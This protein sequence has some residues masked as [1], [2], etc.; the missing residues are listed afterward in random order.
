MVRLH[1]ERVLV[2]V[3]AW[4]RLFTVGVVLIAFTTGTAPADAAPRR[5]PD[6]PATIGPSTPGQAL[7]PPGLQPSRKGNR[8]SAGN[9]PG[10][11]TD[12]AVYAYDAAGRLVG[13]TDPK[14]ETAHYRYDAA[15]NRLGIDRYGSGTLSVLSVVPTRARAGTKVT[16]SGT[17]FA[18]VAADN[19]V[20]FAGKD[21]EVVS[22]SA[23]RLVVTVPNDVPAGKVSV[24]AGGTTAES[25]EPFA[26]APDA[27]RITKVEPA[28]GPPGTEVTITGANFFPEA[29]DNVVRFNGV[30]A[31]VLRAAEGALTVLVPGAAQ[32]GRME[33]ET[34]SG[35][36]TSSGDFTVPLSGDEALYDTTARASADDADPTLL[37]VTSS[38]HQ[39]RIL[40]DAD[41]GDS[42]GFG[43]TNSTYQ[44][45][46]GFRLV[47][48]R[49]EEVGL[50]TLS[51]RSASWH[52]ANLQV[53]GTYQF[54]LD[55]RKDNPGSV[56][57]LISKAAGGELKSDGPTV[58][59]QISR[60]GQG[61][62]WSVEGRAGESL[63]IGVEAGG[64][65]G[66]LRGD[67]YRPDGSQGEHLIVPGRGSASLSIPALPQS[68]T[69]VLVL[70]PDN[71]GTPTLRLTA[72]HSADAGRLTS[73]GPPPVLDMSRPGQGG[74]ATFEAKAG[75]S[76][77]LAA[78]GTT[79]N[80]AVDVLQP[81]GRTAGSFTAMKGR[82][83]DWDSPPLLV[84]GI[85]TVR[86]TP[87]NTDTGK[88]TLT[89]SRP[90][91]LG[92]LPA[93]GDPVALKVTRAGQNGV[94]SFGGRDGTAPAL[95]IAGNTFAKSLFVTVLAPSGAKVLNDGLVGAGRPATFSLPKLSESGNYRVVIAP[96]FAAT[97]SLN[98]SVKGATEVRAS[99][100]PAARPMDRAVM[101]PDTW[102]PDPASLDGQD[103]VTRRGSVPKT[104]GTLW[105]EGDRT[106]L[107][108]H[109]LKLNGLPL[110]KVKV[111]VG[112]VSSLTDEHGRFLLSGIDENAT[113]L[114]VDGS[115]A[116]TK[117]REY[118]VFHIRVRPKDRKIVELGFPVWMT[119]LD[120]AHT[121]SFAA[122]A[123][124]DVVLKTP[125]I[126]GLEVRIPK[127]SVVRDGTG[128]PVTR[129][130][131]TPIPIDRAPYPLPTNRVVPV[132]FTVQPGGTY[133]FPKG[134]QIIYPNYTHEPPGTRVEFMDYDPKGKGWYV[135]GHGA[136]S[137]D[138]R[139][140]VPDEKTRV[141]AFHGAMFNIS[142]LIPWDL[143]RIA[144]VGD[145][146]SGDPVDLGTGLL[147]DA[148]TDLAVADPLGSA[149]VNRT[150]WQGDTRSRAF[151]IGR[152]LSYNA[153]LNSK[154]Q[155]K[156][157]D[158]YLPGGQ[159]VHYVRTSSGTGY[160]DAVFEPSG[161]PSGFH[162]TKIYWNNASG[163]DLRF[164]DGSTWVFPQYGA[165]S[166]VRDR[167]GNS[168][169]IERESFN[170][171][172]SQVNRIVTPG[173]RWIELSWDAQ[174]RVREARDNLG[175][176]TGY[177]YDSAG[178]LETVTDPAG[179][180]SRYTYDGSSNRI[181]SATDARGITYMAN[182]YDAGGRVKEQTLTEGAKFS[183]SYTTDGTGKVA[184]TEVERPGGSV[185]K[186]TFDVE[187]FGVSDTVAHGTDLARKTVY[188]RGKNHRI[189]AVVDPFGRRTE[190]HYDAVGHITSTTEMAGTDKAR[191]SGRTD[192]D[193][194]FDQVSRSTDRLGNATSFGYDVQGDL[195]TITDA[196]GRRTAIDYTPQGQVSKV[197][198]AAGAVS[199]YSYS[200]GE[201]VAV[202]DAEGRVS[203]QFKD[204]VGRPTR[205]SDAAG[206][207]ST[208]AYDKLNQTVRTAD[209]LGSSIAF[210]YDDNG[211]L[212]S[213]TDTLGKTATWTY[214]DADRQR[215]ATDALRA[216]ASFAYDLAGRI[217]RATAR[218]GKAATVD[219]D[220]LGRP[221]A[222]AYG[223]DGGGAAESTATYDY[224]E[225]DRLRQITDSASG[226]QSF[227]YDDYDRTKSV[228]GPTGEVTYGY[229]QADRRIQM[230]AAGTGT[231][232]GYDKSGVLTSLKSGS[233]TV[234]FAL[235]AVG[236]EKTATLPG[237]WTRTTDLD[238]S[239]I[240][241]AVSYARSGAVVGDL[242]YSRDERGLQ[243]GLSGKLA[244]VALPAAETGAVFDDANRLTTLG[245][246][247]FAYDKDGRL[248][249]DGLRDYTWNARGQLTGLT[250]NGAT[251]SFG[252]DP[253][254]GRV[255]K[256]VDGKA[257][258]FLTDNG[259]PLAE[260]DGSG[261]PSATVTASGVD[262]FLTRTEGGRTQ[263]YLTDAMGSVVGLAN[264]DGTIAATYAYD[265][266]GQ[267]QSDGSASSNPYTFTGREDDGTGLLY[268]RSR[269]YDPA[270][271]RFISQD[272]I[273]QA[274]GPNLYQYALSSPTT[275]TDPSGNNPMI[276]GCVV[277]GLMDGGI[278]WL[279][280]RLSGRKVSWGQVATS[281]ASG[282]LTG[283]FMDGLGAFMGAR[284]GSKAAQCLK[285]SFTPDTPVLMADGTTKEIADVRV[286][287]RVIA[288]D[289]E[290]GESGARA[291]TALIRG[292]GEKRLVDLTI[293]GPG[294]PDEPKAGHLTATD[295]H[296]FWVP[297]LHRWVPAEKLKPGQWLRTSSGTWVQ[298]AAVSHRAAKSAVNNLTVV[299]LH[300][301]YVLAG[302]SPVLVH[303]CRE[304]FAT[305]YLDRVEGHATVK[306]EMGD[307]VLHTEQIGRPGTYAVPAIRTAP[308]SP[309]TIKVRIP[310]PNAGGALAYQEVKLGKNLGRYD[311][312]T[313]SCV[314]Y[315]AEVLQAGGVTDLPD[316]TSSLEL[317]KYLIRRHNTG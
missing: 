229:D 64:A 120:T 169:R 34:P 56:S 79:V 225:Q 185:R 207:E 146:L 256:Q 15:G 236:R 234:S 172:K 140:V 151:G 58:T 278:D 204:A 91:D 9:G 238:G 179:R 132:F 129:L 311:L 274:G 19:R 197:T 309:T 135:Y 1:G 267:V 180:T 61:G 163:W 228:L 6:L 37:T 98:L 255:S 122:P 18:S 117:D 288:T 224:D 74:V 141:W 211:N 86:V 134:A 167:H 301:Y 59:T 108:G 250:R 31:R 150:Y 73:D 245:G 188:E 54:V 78:T 62:R 156:E 304:G 300:T 168:V 107:T 230:T 13:V 231:A 244:K 235:D 11:T 251:S 289:P 243:A 218:S 314:T 217:K 121:V 84:S 12:S 196:E 305:V 160:R 241:R 233:D 173:G 83:T 200:H 282:C 266:N 261:K 272:P 164:R 88:A 249:S 25:Q 144:D 219:Y 90:V 271:G 36:V 240:V 290:T 257:S 127:G 175:R 38:G 181:A 297:D 23:T 145:W 165:V 142:D 14:G 246:R 100:G 258:K 106:A 111:S 222:A 77:S 177:T 283:M 131:I 193:G 39:A 254:G 48:P 174:H 279:G 313:R 95:S 119:P 299:G 263:V 138:G 265:P 72:S 242:N 210:G 298:V 312:D 276:A 63:G 292:E 32:S 293:A 208:V 148:R 65:D 43:L 268:Y 8:T 57:V 55:P 66:Y 70:D 82:D 30:V 97:G 295:G 137:P 17:G 114:V 206:A 216:T 115:T 35:A 27:P 45:A 161:T 96:Q 16:V 227:A 143:S 125:K 29:A 170:G 116:N 294:G 195:R 41:R 220:L 316:M 213:L 20:S 67:L 3:P 154:E 60:F 198:D 190:L 252:Y 308:H 110:A 81:D 80:A 33:V 46:V 280:Q 184:A 147:T 253:L 87:K 24:S 275:Y 49:G 232:Y 285:N 317:T 262:R 118:G 71:G 248:T 124:R 182:A 44:K 205:L 286:G 7:V 264:D 22:A 237:G 189:E 226:K 68:G 166:E 221:K 159:R 28:S 178:R 94:A 99:T 277:G 2:R 171:R 203:R 4:W 50:G 75:E 40:F 85:H 104:P 192:F 214:D 52:A 101:G 69:Y 303:N 259:N 158:L 126:P 191:E 273:G 26:P 136:V 21:A 199:E 10:P 153:F 149:E 223:V 133:V 105:G 92:T 281:A 51:G 162:G 157:V 239:G 155:Y 89:L 315:C 76:V 5:I 215:T 296:P 194:P 302:N 183:F 130:G 270:T 53:S 291:V 152:D 307:D 310:L 260:L 202:K 287:D 103:W 102:D 212:T 187:G 176:T 247:S 284:G 269:Y 112:K 109:V 186:V 128:K 47:S 209:P 42:L 113:T 306:V 93:G 201:Q 123:E 139:Q